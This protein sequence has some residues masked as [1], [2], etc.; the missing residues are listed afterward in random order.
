M[1]SRSAPDN[2][3]VISLLAE[4]V[5]FADREKEVARI[6]KVFRAPGANLVVYGDRRMGKS[7][8]MERAAQSVRR[9]RGLVAIAAFSTASDPAEAAQRVLSAVQKEVRPSWRD[10]ISKIAER[11]DVTVEIVPSSEPAALPTVK[12]G[13]GAERRDD[14]TTLLPDVLD[15]V[16]AQMEARHRTLGIGLDEF[17]RIHE[18]GGEDAEWALREAMQR[19]R[20]LSYVLA[21]SKRT[22]IEAMV[23]SKGRAL[24][25]LAE[26]MEF[27]PIDDD[28][29]AAW[30]TE[31]GA[32]SGVAIGV[33]AATLIVGLAKPRTRDIVQLARMVWDAALGSGTATTDHAHAAMD[34]LVRD[35][36]ALYEAIWLRLNARQQM[37]LRALAADESTQITA[38]ETLRTYRLGAKSTAQSAIDSLIEAEHLTRITPGR[39]A[40]DDPFFRRWT[41]LYGLADI[42]V[43]APTIPSIRG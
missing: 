41:Q 26:P 1:S 24:W 25:K 28:V 18:W 5:H 32:R 33:D 35:H 38:S 39:Y 23:G 27:G 16:N 17:Q 42:G 4:G 21:G 30:I 8:A 14:G 9:G 10:F 34:R 11:L 6:A 20:S 12:F 43:P 7:S 13:F 31:S 37:V 22:L 19:H 2:P 40:F 29:M 36:A 15:A 3:F